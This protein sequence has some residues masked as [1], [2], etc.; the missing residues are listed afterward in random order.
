MSV[1][2][3]SDYRTDDSVKDPVCQPSCSGDQDRCSGDYIIPPTPDAIQ[4][5][6]IS[7]NKNM[8]AGFI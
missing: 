8:E 2:S 4:I 6:H 1:S 3:E 7:S 5:M